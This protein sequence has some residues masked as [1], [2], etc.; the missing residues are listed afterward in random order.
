MQDAPGSVDVFDGKLDTVL[1]LGNKSAAIR[2]L[3]SFARCEG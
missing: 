2:V 3:M 1:L